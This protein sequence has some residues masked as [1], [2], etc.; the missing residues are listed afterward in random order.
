MNGN[1][2]AVPD[3]G[4]SL[5]DVLRTDLGISSTK[6]GCAPQ[7]QCGCCTVLVDG[8]PRVAC[9]TPVRRVRGRQVTTLEGLEPQRRDRWAQAF[10]D[11]GGSQCGFC[12]PGIIVRLE[13]LA[14]SNSLAG[15]GVLD[16]DA[17][18]Q[19][20]LAHLCRCTGWQTIVEAAETLVSI[21]SSASYVDIGDQSALG[22]V[23]DLEKAGQ[24][25]TLEGRAPQRVS[26][27]VALGQAGFA[28]DLVPT[29]HLV[30]VRDT[31]GTWVAA[32]TLPEARALAGKVQGRRTTAPHR[33]PL[34]LPDGD[35]VATLR[36]TWT[37][38][39]YLETD[40]AWCLS[41]IHI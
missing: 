6:D 17:V 12:T 26:P 16:R 28:A 39:A 41:L 10:C 21:G 29:D 22:N 32:Q 15:D 5:L 27:S 1:P 37:D 20:L 36:T 8:K 34:E 7:G 38:G 3:Q 14:R 33:F 25:A 30:A 2:V 13:S 23:R 18:D 11:T 35:W 40:A 31:E 9:V 19:A 4:W 24:R